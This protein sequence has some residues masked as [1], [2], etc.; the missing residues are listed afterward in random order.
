MILFYVFCSIIDEKNENSE[1]MYIIMEYASNG[2]LQGYLRTI[3]KNKD[4]AENGRNDDA[5][6]SGSGAHTNDSFLT[7]NEIIGFGMQIARGMEYL[8]SEKV[9]FD[10]IPLWDFFIF[11]LEQNIVLNKYC[12]ENKPI[13]KISHIKTLQNSWENKKINKL[14]TSTVYISNVDCEAIRAPIALKFGGLL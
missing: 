9:C 12:T 2:S 7:P 13:P 14:L 8:A 1:P 3:R 6:P 4:A 11:T 5:G 10:S